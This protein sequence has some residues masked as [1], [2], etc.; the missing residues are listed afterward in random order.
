[1]TF[2]PTKA[3]Y[4]ALSVSGVG[5]RTTR[6]L[7][8]GQDITDETVGTTIFNV[9]SGAVGEVQLNRST[10]DVSGSVTSTGQVLMSTRSGTN[11][12]HGN[13][14][15]NFQDYRAGFASVQG[16]QAPFQRNQ[17]GGYAGGPIFKDKLF[18]FGGGERIKQ[19]EEDVASGA[20]PLFQAIETEFPYTPAPFH[21]T[22]SMARLDY[23]APH[24]IHMFV[25]GAYSVNS[26]DATFGYGPYQIYQNRDNV[27]AI[28]G[29]A[30]LI[31]GRFTHSLR[32]GYEKFHNLLVDGTAALGNSIYNPSTGPDNQITLVGDLN[33]GPNFL[34][35][36]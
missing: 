4:S 14:F 34:A 21:D 17:F 32:F 30:D 20:N 2:D 11:S 16:L 18:F 8:D 10:Q 3:G 25:R 24:N 35:P 26:D 6:I 28:V 9:P 31:S 36:Q 27:P 1:M 29:G 15:Y 13:T 33:S 7:L 23:S 19:T 12:F 22:F 5:G